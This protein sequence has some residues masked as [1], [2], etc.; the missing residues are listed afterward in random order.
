[1]LLEVLG[2]EFDGVLGCDYYSAYRKY[3]RL[4]EN[5]LLQFCLAH[6]IRDVKFLAEH[7]ERKNRTYGKRLVENLRELFGIIHRRD[8]Y[9]SEEKFIAALENARNDLVWNATIES[10]G[11]REALALE[12]R[13]HMHTASYFRFITEANVEPTNN[14]AEQAIRFVAIHR[15]MTQGTR[16]EDGRH[17]PIIPLGSL[18]LRMTCQPLLENGVDVRLGDRSVKVPLPLEKRDDHDS[19]FYHGKSPFDSSRGSNLERLCSHFQ[20]IVAETSLIFHPDPLESVA[21]CS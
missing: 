3:M 4:N 11:T 7:P 6:F 8:E 20:H 5:V 12:A 15:R 10:P 2:Q 18:K 21:T 19:T 14:L 17:D 9:S 1:V 13:F 16:S